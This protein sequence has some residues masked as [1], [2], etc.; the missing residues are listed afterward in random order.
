MEVVDIPGNH[1]LDSQEFSLSPQSPRGFHQ[2]GRGS[3]V[4]FQTLVGGESL[5]SLSSH[6]ICNHSC[7]AFVPKWFL[8]HRLVPS[9][10]LKD[11]KG[12][13]MPMRQ[14]RMQSTLIVATVV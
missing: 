9:R 6:R 4:V 11:V 1:S 8:S 2:I 3:A 7:T 14:V 5:D 13:V 12:I 10:G